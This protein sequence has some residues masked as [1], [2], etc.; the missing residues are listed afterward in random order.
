[1]FI[2]NERMS[3]CMCMSM[4]QYAHLLSARSDTGADGRGLI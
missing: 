4:P 2:L 1:M 3:G